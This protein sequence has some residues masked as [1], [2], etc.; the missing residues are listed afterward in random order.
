MYACTKT[1]GLILF[2]RYVFFLCVWVLDTSSTAIDTVFGSMEHKRACRQRMQKFLKE[3]EFIGLSDDAELFDLMY[4]RYA[5]YEPDDLKLLSKQNVDKLI[6]Q[7]TTSS[8]FAFTFDQGRQLRNYCLGYTTSKSSSSTPRIMRKLTGRSKSIVFGGKKD[9]NRP[10]RRKEKSKSRV[11]T[12]NKDKDKNKDNKDKD[13]DEDMENK[14]NEDNE[15][16]KEK[17]RKNKEKK[18]DKKDK[19]DKNK[20]L[21]KENSKKHV[22]NKKSKKNRDEDNDDN[23]NENETE[24]DNSKEDSKKSEEYDDDGN[25]DFDDDGDNG[26]DETEEDMMSPSEELCHFIETEASLGHI[27]C[28]VLS[29]ILVNDYGVRGINDFHKRIKNDKKRKQFVN[30]AKKIHT[31]GGI[32]N[33]RDFEKFLRRIK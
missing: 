26:Q 22:K 28:K 5:V 7:A 25:G 12:R 20:K 23:A 29:E 14:D 30:E 8:K 27:F 3:K 4:E 16:N 15:D 11:L 33:H 24:N 13:K 18:K 31:T 6:K 32:A 1:T 10:K 17:K 21:K 9:S 19:K 2:V